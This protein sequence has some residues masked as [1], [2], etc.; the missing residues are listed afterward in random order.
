[1]EMLEDRPVIVLQRQGALRLHQELVVHSR[2]RH[3]VGGRGHGQRQEVDLRAIAPHVLLL[4]QTSP[5]VA[6]CQRDVGRVPP[7]VVRVLPVGRLQRVHPLQHRR[8][9]GAAQGVQP[10]LRP[11]R[12]E[13]LRQR[14]MAL[15]LN[16][17]D[18]NGLPRVHVQSDLP[19]RQAHRDLRTAGPPPLDDARLHLHLPHDV[20][21][22]PEAFL[23]ACQRAPESEF[24]LVTLPR[25]PFVQRVPPQGRVQA[26]HQL[27]RALR[28]LGVGA[29]VRQGGAV[30]PQHP[31]DGLLQVPHQRI[32]GLVR[33]P[34]LR[35]ARRGRRRRAHAAA[36]RTR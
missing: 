5:Q 19:V 13:H 10:A 26:R 35:E 22:C 4:R 28:R 21:Q 29:R 30:P 9:V 20:V 36:D 32:H 15:F 11:N 25:V 7:V 2:V 1:M 6:R 18:V 33:L 17:E 8:A 34:P 31:G 12:H 23:P 3:V 14:L 16:A 27:R 24:S